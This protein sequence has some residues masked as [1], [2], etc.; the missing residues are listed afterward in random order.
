[1]I[2]L[3]GHVK[4]TDFGLAKHAKEKRYSFCGSLEYMCPEVL[5]KS[6]HSFEVDYYCLGVLLYEMT[7]GCPPFY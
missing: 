3:G 1:M 6:G 2:D 4:I 5:T 7:V